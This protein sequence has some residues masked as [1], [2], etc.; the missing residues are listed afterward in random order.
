MA[1]QEKIGMP[2]DEFIRQGFDT[3]TTHGIC[4]DCFRQQK[5]AF[6]RSKAARKI[7]PAT[8]ETTS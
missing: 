5:E 7:E 3:P 8:G 4:Q 2:L 1:V 6:E